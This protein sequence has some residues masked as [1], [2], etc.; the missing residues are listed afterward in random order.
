MNTDT[1]NTQFLEVPDLSLTV[2]CY[3]EEDSL[4]NTVQQLVESFR[5]KGIHVELVLV[6]NGSI[7]QT[8]KIIDELISEGLPVVKEVVEH[9]QG[10]GHGVLCGFR[11]CRGKFV[12]IIPADNEVD[13]RDVVQLYEIL[14][15]SKTPKLVKVRRRFRMDGFKRK[16]TSIIYN[17]SANALFLGLGSIDLN[18]SPKILPRDYLERMKLESKDWFLDAEIIIKAKQM[19]LPVYEMNVIAQLRQDGIS[20]VRMVACWEF[21]LNL[22]KY[23]F[24][25]KWQHN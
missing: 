21:F 4:R 8:R 23:R 9:N 3:N 2:P 16:V 22:L 1:A 14:S 19:G 13:A 15:Q 20:H 7:D 11:S 24:Q 10:Y 18:G 25:K 12:G 5:G 17:F 6:D